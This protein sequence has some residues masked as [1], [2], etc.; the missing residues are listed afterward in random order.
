MKNLVLTCGDINGIGPEICIKTVN[1]IYGLQERKIFLICP[2][3]IFATTSSAIRPSFNYKIVKDI[4]SRDT[5]Y[6]SVTIIDIGKYKQKLGSP[7][8]DSGKAAFIA[9]DKAY[10]LISSNFADAMITAPV[11]KT[12]FQMAGIKYPGQT[13]LLARLSKSKKY[14]MVFLSNDFICGLT[15]IHE[16][17]KNVSKRLSKQIIVQ[18]I[19][20]LEDT[21]E[22]DLDMMSPKIAVLGLNPHAGENG[23]IGNEEILFIKPAIKSF[24]KNI[25]N[26][27]FA[28]DAFFGN[29]L[30]KEYTAVLGMYHVQVLIPFKMLNF[31]CGVN[32]TAGLPIIRTSPDHGTGYDI[33]GKGVANC[34]SMLE[35]VSWAEKIISNRRLKI[36][37]R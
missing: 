12:A 37:A 1:R 9:I 18:A 35:A 25:I 36:N 22:T 33:S 3:N 20:I 21:L 27:P 10:K 2:E 16:A 26:G 13:E 11:S 8:K 4:N 31:N 24:K 28:P 14:L 34:Q 19:N 30:Y 32:F 17:I 29:Q 7:T 23:K 5:D 6:N 15:T